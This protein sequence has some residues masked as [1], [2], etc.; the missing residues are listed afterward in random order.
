ML[1]E[2]SLITSLKSVT[3]LCV[4][5][6]GCERSGGGVSYVFH[7]L[8]TI[9]ATNNIGKIRSMKPIINYIFTSL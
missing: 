6:G 9:Y 7:I 4:V 3:P 1:N 5:G 8:M 2:T